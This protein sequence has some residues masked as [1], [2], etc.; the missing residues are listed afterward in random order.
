V[1]SSVRCIGLVTRVGGSFISSP[2]WTPE[3]YGPTSLKILSLGGGQAEAA[4][5]LE[6]STQEIQAEERES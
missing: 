5:V 1:L 6:L 3:V 2:L 4:R